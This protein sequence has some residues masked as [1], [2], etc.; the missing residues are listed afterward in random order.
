MI[1]LQH[2]DKTGSLF[3]TLPLIRTLNQDHPLILLAQAISW[4]TL[5]E[6]LVKFYDLHA[7]RPGLPL[8]LMI[9][10]M[11]LKYLFNYS[12]ERVIQLWTENPY[13]QAFTGEPR[14]TSEP[15]CDPSE[16]T[17]FRKRIGKDGCEILLAESVRI[18]GV[19]VLEKE[20]I[21]DTT[22]QEKYTHYPTDSTLI[23]DVINQCW[24]VAYHMGVTL[25]RSYKKDVKKFKSQ[26][27]FS[28]GK[29]KSKQKNK[30]LKSLRTRANTI[31]RDLQR[32]LPEDV[33]ADDE[34][35][36]FFANAHKA[37][38]QQ[39]NDKNKI[40][41][42]YEPHI[43]CI[44]KGKAHTRFEFGTKVSFVIGKAKGII[45]GALNFTDNIYDGDTIEPALSQLS[46]I[47]DGY[48]PALFIADRGYRGR[49]EV[50]GVKIL[51]PYDLKNDNADAKEVKK[52]KDC[53]LRRSSVEPVIGHLKND[54]RLAV[55]FLHGIDGDFVNP[56]LAAVAYNFK[57]FIGHGKLMAAKT[58]IKLKKSIKRKTN[59]MYGLPFRKTQTV[60]SLFDKTIPP[61][62]VPAI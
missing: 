6:K 25:R 19:T 44:A 9:G 45:L 2:Q 34:V 1:K 38:N 32:K 55:N 29:M 49:N 28:K 48:Q 27:N 26:I 14:F 43:R 36:V 53:C 21:G 41:S 42:I 52:V 33:L 59:K 4:R 5:E 15:P 40:Y 10:L 7:G 30:A 60:A 20:V 62:P 22:V 56:L 31:L 11:L 50:G 18:N 16:L 12:D 58:L 17:H 46:A 47:H 13:Y 35:K 24:R 8:Q 3:Q 23:L 37:V 54:H 51:T 61:E 39:K 57:K